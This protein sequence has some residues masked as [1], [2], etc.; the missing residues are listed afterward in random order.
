M[1]DLVAIRQGLAANLAAIEGCQVSAFR[2]SQPTPPTLQVMGVD[3]VVYDT[4]GFGRRAVYHHDTLKLIVHGFVGAVT[5]IGSQ[6]RLGAWLASTGDESVKQALEADPT[7]TKRLLFDGTIETDQT[8][9]AET[10][11]VIRYAGDLLVPL[12]NVG[13]VIGGE[14]EVEITIDSSGT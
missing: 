12:P 6:I 1:A 11:R 3:E 7:L 14:W 5:D 4:G 2:L 9:Q 13:D 10:L 8:P